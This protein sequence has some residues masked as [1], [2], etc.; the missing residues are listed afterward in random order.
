[1]GKPPLDTRWPSVLDARFFA[2]GRRAGGDGSAPFR[3][4]IG[5]KKLRTGGKNRLTAN[6]AMLDGR[7]VTVKGAVPR[8]C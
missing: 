2:N 3:G 7:Q 6:V 1:M 8:A 4:K 5:A